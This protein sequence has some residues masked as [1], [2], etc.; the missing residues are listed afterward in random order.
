MTRHFALLSVVLVLTIAGCYVPSPKL[1]KTEIAQEKVGLAG[2]ESVSVSVTLGVGKLKLAGG[3]DSLLDARFEYNIPDWKPAVSYRVEDGRGRLL[4]EQPSRVVG[5]A[6][7]GSVRYDW[8]LKLNSG[9]P[10]ELEVDMGVGKSEVDLKG[11]SLRRFSLDA[12]VGEGTIDLSGPR[13]S[14]LEATIQAGVGKLTL[15]LPSDVGVRVKAQ[16]GLGHVNSDG[17]RA[18]GDAWVNEAWGKTRT[19][20]RVE[21]QGG[22]GEV[23]MRLVG[24]PA[25]GSI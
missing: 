4:V 5:A 17:L 8:E 23:E 24:D 9:L 2:A 20:V 1:T 19:S 10:L 16:A 21:V 25:G 6:W 12:G 22:I 14:D 15:V 13:P 7:P 18:D 3:A 11:L